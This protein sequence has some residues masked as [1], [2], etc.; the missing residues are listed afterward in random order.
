MTAPVT[1]E[2]AAVSANA[3]ETG[4][5]LLRVFMRVVPSGARAR[6][7]TEAWRSVL[8]HAGVTASSPVS[9]RLRPVSRRYRVH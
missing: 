7:G 2:A 8:S 5:W 9:R 4:L 6:V 1:M 3:M